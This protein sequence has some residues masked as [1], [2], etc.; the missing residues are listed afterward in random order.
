MNSRPLTYAQAILEAFTQLFESDPR[1]F[2]IGQGVWSPWY[3]GASM[4]DLDKRFGRDRVIDSPV[5]ENAMTG[6]ALGAA[7]AGLRPIV[8]HPRMDFM[9]LATDQIIN[10]AANWCSMFGGRVHAPVVIRAIINRGGEQGA[11]HSQA[12]HASFA[13]VP[14]LKVVMPA[15]PYDAKG[16]LIA[17]VADGNPVLY[18][19]DRWLYQEIGDV[20]TELYSTPIGKAFVRRAGR[21]VTVV[22]ISHMVAESMKAATT[23]ATDGVD[24]EV[25]DVCSVKPLD[26]ATIVASVRKTGRLVVADTGWRN[27]G[28]PAEIIARVAEQIPA[29]L[30][31]PVVRV[32]LPDAPAPTSGALE[33]TYFL[34]A[35]NVVAAVKRVLNRD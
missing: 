11:Q 25:I 16:L 21:D 4:T 28:V 23:L 19:D 35:A 24:V 7:L 2:A 3:V 31:A 29:A 22:A 10:E 17:A 8:I 34:S 12:L 18:I 1:V 13:H 15:T 30:R 9:L 20:P 32:V 27:G 5:S 26:D 33:Q 14:G 6:A